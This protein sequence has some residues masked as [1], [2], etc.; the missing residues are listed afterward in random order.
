MI[1]ILPAPLS[2]FRWRAHSNE[3]DGGADLKHKLCDSRQ[4]RNICRSDRLDCRVP[5]WPNPMAVTWTPRNILSAKGFGGRDYRRAE[6]RKAL[7]TWLWTCGA[8][9]QRT[10]LPEGR[11]PKGIGD[12]RTTF[13][14]FRAA[15]RL[16]EGRKP[17]G[18]GDCLEFDRPARAIDR[19]PEGRKPKGIGDSLNWFCY[20]KFC[21]ITGGQKAE[22]HWR[23]AA[24]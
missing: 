5:L 8:R 9:S 7:E 14:T 17:K 6:S 12:L 20:V 22:R 11:K 1:H 13:S 18:I 21:F 2:S 24:V 16:P 15:I 3:K 4:L 23:L 10:P 19:L